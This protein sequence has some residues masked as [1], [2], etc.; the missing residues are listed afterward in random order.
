[1]QN[2]E[3]PAIIEARA[4]LRLV[5]LGNETLDGARELI[6]IP[7]PEA[8]ALN[9]FVAVGGKA[10]APIQYALRFRERVLAQFEELVHENHLEE[11]PTHHSSERPGERGTLPN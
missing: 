8:S 4:I 6:G 3:D 2:Y 10:G 5:T 11:S 1:M 7:G 9:A